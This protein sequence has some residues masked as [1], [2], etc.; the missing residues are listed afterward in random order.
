MLFV[1]YQISA[2]L[3]YDK[4]PYNPE[5]SGYASDIVLIVLKERVTIG[6]YVLPACLKTNQSIGFNPGAGVRG[7][8]RTGASSMGFCPVVVSYK[9]SLPIL[10]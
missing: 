7:I 6:P 5:V 9:T 1:L 10:L 2:I 3:F 4:K 8:V